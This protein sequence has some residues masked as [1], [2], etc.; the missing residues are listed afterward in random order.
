MSIAAAFFLNHPHETRADFLFSISPCTEDLDFQIV[1][2]YPR[3]GDV[4]NLRASS[5][6]DAQNWMQAIEQA[7][8]KC[9]A[10][11]KRASRKSNGSKG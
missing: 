10:A 2:A 8:L 9:I 7:R 4:V 1:L 6:R 5:A 3:G 11:E